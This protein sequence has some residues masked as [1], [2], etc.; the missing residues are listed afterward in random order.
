[1]ET[2]TIQQKIILGAPRHKVYEA[3]LDPKIHAEFTQA[4]AENDIKVGG[5]FSAYDGFIS[6]TNLELKKDEKIVQRWTT[7][8]LPKGHFTEVIFEFKDH[9]KG[10]ELLFTQTNVPDKYYKSLVQGWRD[11]YWKPLK[12]F[13]AF[14]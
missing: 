5:K 13:F 3:I 9:D 6:G 1:M 8:D 2:K 14:V 10:T 12:S 11:F 4:K 7:T